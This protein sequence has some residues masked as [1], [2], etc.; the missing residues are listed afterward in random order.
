METELIVFY[1]DLC[2]DGFAAAALFYKYSDKPT[3]VPV[4]YRAMPKLE[5][6]KKHYAHFLDFTP[7]VEWVEENKH[8]LG[9]LVIL[10]HHDDKE[11]DCKTI[12]SIF[13]G[14]IIHFDRTLAGS[15]LT[16]KYLNHGEMPEVI[17]LINNRDLWIATD[18]EREYHE[19]FVRF[20]KKGNKEDIFPPFNALLEY[21]K[22]RVEAE[23]RP[24]VDLL[25]ESRNK[26]ITFHL[27]KKVCFPVETNGV[28]R[29]TAVYLSAPYY[30]A[31]EAASMLL[32]KR[33]DVDLVVNVTLNK[34]GLGLSFRS[35]KGTGWAQR[36]AHVFNGGGHPDAA[37]GVFDYPVSFDILHAL[38]LQ[39]INKV[40][41]NEFDTPEN[42]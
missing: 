41:N 13:P 30:Y 1:H 42:Q 39:N 35:R 29:F 20:L 33:D 31:S 23:I 32:A 7:P 26:N 28:F 24:V 9:G 34:K 36:L 25:I 22:E 8:L 12:R 19:Y 3:F 38:I 16:W 5:E 17:R 27:D 6:G 10:D 37:G 21:S 15:G 14:T 11:E 40:S 2:M 18:N 4:N